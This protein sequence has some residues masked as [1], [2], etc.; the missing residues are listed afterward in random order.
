[1]SWSSLPNSLRHIIFEYTR[2]FRNKERARYEDRVFVH[3]HDIEWL[4]CTSEETGA[5]RFFC[6]PVPHTKL[7]EQAYLTKLG[8][9]FFHEVSLAR[10]MRLV[11][12]M[13]PTAVCL[14]SS[15]SRLCVFDII[16]G[17]LLYLPNYKLL[18]GPH[19]SHYSPFV[20]LQHVLGLTVVFNE[21]AEPVWSTHDDVSSVDV[22]D[23][24]M[25]FCVENSLFEA[26]ESRKV[27]CTQHRIQDVAQYARKGLVVMDRLNLYCID[28]DGIL[29]RT[30]PTSISSP[31]SHIGGVLDCGRIVCQRW[32]KITNGHCCSWCVVDHD[33]GEAME[34]LCNVLGVRRNRVIVSRSADIAVL[35]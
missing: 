7:G 4:C 1:M 20:A 32:C 5:F 27:F 29:K 11:F 28:W 22:F 9:L 2:Q 35:E 14:E 33:T 13:S 15:F 18:L 16:N 34:L 8:E 23:G 19:S 21:K 3:Q 12:W 6:N 24:R 10:H 17:E 26:P 25:L 31:W 30:I